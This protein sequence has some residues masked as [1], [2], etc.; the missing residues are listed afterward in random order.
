MFQKS[1]LRAFFCDNYNEFAKIYILWYY[2]QHFEE[3]ALIKI[4]VFK[5]MFDSLK[6]N[7]YYN[8]MKLLFDK[9]VSDNKIVPFDDELYDKMDQVYI[10]GL[11]VSIHIKYLKPKFPPGKCYDRS[12]YMFFCFDDAI[13]VR[14]DNKDLELE[15]GKEK[16]GH[17]WIE[18]G[19]YVYDPSLMMRFDKELYYEIYNPINVTKCNKD[20]YCSTKDRCAL[21]TDV[22]NTSID[23]FKPYGKKRIELFITMPLVKEIARYSDNPKFIDELNEFI[24]LIQY[25][26][27]EIYNEL[28]DKSMDDS[29]NELSGSG[30]EVLCKNYINKKRSI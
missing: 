29:I 7:L 28:N 1:V 11:P 9:G 13:L 4:G 30:L 8:K 21:Y 19:D 14:G 16:S 15:Y 6:K 5:N 24:K 2:I 26:E 17:G 23:D 22:K 3:V 25:N 27:E 18:I 12:L 10:S 20:E